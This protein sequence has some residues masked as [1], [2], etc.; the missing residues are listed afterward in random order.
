MQSRKN[1]LCLSRKGKGMNWVILAK[2]CHSQ[3]TPEAKSSCGALPSE[4]ERVES[5]L[6]L[7]PSQAG[8]V[9]SG[10]VGLRVVWRTLARRGSG[11]DVVAGHS[12]EKSR[13]PA[14]DPMALAGAAPQ[15]VGAD[16]QL[17]DYLYW[18][19]NS[20]QGGGKDYST[21]SSELLAE[22]EHK[23]PIKGFIQ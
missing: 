7:N 15:P 20:C 23:C 5:I 8:G 4:A 16:D 3:I 1:V 13:F 18:F 11:G 2:K 19:S 14:S 17:R 22:W 12:P 6:W 9:P 10:A 21:T